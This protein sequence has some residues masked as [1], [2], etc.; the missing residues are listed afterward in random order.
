MY[1]KLLKTL[2]KSRFQGTSIQH[3]VGR[4]GPAYL[5]GSYVFENVGKIRFKFITYRVSHIA[6]I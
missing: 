1:Q 4:G 6:M 5:L 2:I 3:A